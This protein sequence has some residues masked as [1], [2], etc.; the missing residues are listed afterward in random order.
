MLWASRLVL[1]HIYTHALLYLEVHFGVCLC[2]DNLVNK[3][4]GELECFYSPFVYFFIH[5]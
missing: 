3:A 5:I 4:T 2:V 1:A